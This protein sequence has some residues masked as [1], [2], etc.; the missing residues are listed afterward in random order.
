MGL[1]YSS[2]FKKKLMRE[3]LFCL[4]LIAAT[5]ADEFVNLFLQFR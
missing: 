1:E 4:A 5:T 2:D 3:A